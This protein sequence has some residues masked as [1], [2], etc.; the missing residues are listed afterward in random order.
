MPI[1][2]ESFPIFFLLFIYVVLSA[3]HT[4]YL[5]LSA[6]LLGRTFLSWQH[7]GL[8][9]GLCALCIL[10]WRVVGVIGISIPFPANLMVGIVLYMAFGSW[11][12]AKRGQTKNGDPIGWVGGLRLSGLAL[13]MLMV[14]N[15]GINVV[16]TGV[17]NAVTGIDI[18]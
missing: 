7:A 4:A 9:A 8:F 2:I 17:F 12:F 5:K 13:L 15:A 18:S 3:F 10:I 14:T 11:F 6:N 16:I 1:L